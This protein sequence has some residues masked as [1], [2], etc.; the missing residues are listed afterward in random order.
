M[1]PFLIKY[2]STDIPNYCYLIAEIGIII[3]FNSYIAKDLI[4]QA[5]AGFDAVKFQKGL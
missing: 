5:S 1:D 3:R 4:A 2:K